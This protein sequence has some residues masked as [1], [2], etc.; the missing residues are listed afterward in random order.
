MGGSD[1]G[2]SGGPAWGA[3]AEARRARPEANFG[4]LCGRD[5]GVLAEPA[6]GT[7]FGHLAS[8]AQGGTHLACHSSIFCL[9]R[10]YAYNGDFWTDV[11]HF[12]IAQRERRTTVPRRRR[13]GSIMVLK[14]TKLEGGSYADF[15]GSFQYLSVCFIHLGALTIFNLQKDGFWGDGVWIVR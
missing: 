12:C 9:C 5:T 11:H 15:T 4:T 6:R 8:H 7:F 2:A 13:S 10:S 3:P 14:N 1:F